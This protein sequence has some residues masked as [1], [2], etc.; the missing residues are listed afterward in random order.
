MQ[1]RFAVFA[2]T[3]T[4]CVLLISC[5][6]PPQQKTRYI[7]SVPSSETTASSSST[8]R[9][10]TTASLPSAAAADFTRMPLLKLIFSTSLNINRIDD[11]YGM[12]NR[13]IRHL[14][15]VSNCD[16]DVLKGF[17][18]DGWAPV[19]LLQYGNKRRLWTVAGYDDAAE[20]IQLA[21]PATRNSRTISYSD[22][23]KESTSSAGKCVLCGV[24][25][26]ELTEAKVHSVLK[27]YLPA[28][29]VS[30]VKVRSR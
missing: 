25:P 12:T 10:S 3:L 24:I 4:L 21:N 9:A 8:S 18:A 5:G 22:F 14:S 11:L 15:V 6:P 16:L 29:R 23:R 28:A 1:T 26:G 20:Q 27:S 7:P 19:V 30:Q 13:Q 17:V 2:F